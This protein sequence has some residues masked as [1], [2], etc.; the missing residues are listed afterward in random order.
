MR[1]VAQSRPRT[2]AGADLALGDPP[3]VIALCQVASGQ[4]G[5]A[6]LLGVARP[7]NLLSWALAVPQDTA[8]P[9]PVS[10]AAEELPLVPDSSYRAY[11]DEP[12]PALSSSCKEGRMLTASFSA[13]AQHLLLCFPDSWH[14]LQRTADGDLAFEAYAA[15]GPCVPAPERP[16]SPSSSTH[17]YP[18]AAAAA[19]AGYPAWQGGLL[20]A[21]P[22]PEQLLVV[23]WDAGSSLHSFELQHGQPGAVAHIQ[24]CAAWE[25]DPCSIASLSSGSIV[26]VAGQLAV[27][28]QLRTVSGPHEGPAA[29]HINLSKPHRAE[30]SA[31]PLSSTRSQS[32]PQKGGE[33]LAKAAAQPA[34]SSTPGQCSASLVGSTGACQLQAQVDRSLLAGILLVPVALCCCCCCQGRSLTVRMLLVWTLLHYTQAQV[35]TVNRV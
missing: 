5:Q 25:T 35:L 11:Q 7:C 23:M 30:E 34:A 16:P 10:A 26:A 17:L 31:G 29:V 18:A 27:G 33:S 14:L 22:H 9:A 3:E 28:G 19:A 2:H 21:V 24:I 13:E 6:V 12:A 20:H 15:G 1:A 8:L 32:E 4:T